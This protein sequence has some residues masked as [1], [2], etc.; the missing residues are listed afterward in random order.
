L[1]SK[2]QAGASGTFAL[3]YIQGLL[4]RSA[5]LGIRATYWQKFF[6]QRVLRPE[7]YGGL[8]H[9]RAANKIEEYPIHS[10]FLNAHVLSRSFSRNGTYL[11]SHAFPEGAPLHSSYP[12]GAAQSAAVAVTI[13]KAFF[14][15]EA[16]IPNPVQPDHKDPAK[17][18][19][20][21]GPPLTVGG[22]RNKLAWNFG[23]GR[24][25]AGIHWRSDYSASLPLG[26]AVAIALLRDER[27]TYHEPFGGFSFTRFDGTKV[28]V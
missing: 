22:E 11:L 9:N 17:L 19:P 27:A 24:D 7:A 21:I 2:T 6:V 4:P 12:G 10:E 13:L 25:W 3:P 26:E 1:K 20:Y 8:V 15:E 28:T 18:I 23:V 14:D 16:V 5:S